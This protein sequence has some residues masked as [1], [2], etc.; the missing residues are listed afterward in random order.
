MIKP[1]VS[2]TPFLCSLKTSKNL[3]VFWCFQ[4]LEKRCI[5]NKWVKIL[6]W[7]EFVLELLTVFFVR[8]SCAFTSIETI[9]RTFPIFV[10]ILLWFPI[11]TIIFMWHYHMNNGEN[12]NNKVWNYVK[13]NLNKRKNEKEIGY[14][15]SYI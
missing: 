7:S 12:K 3:T 4:G 5:G 1:F 10:H 9:Y 14:L 11:I 13:H 6:C 15:I 2:N 8:R